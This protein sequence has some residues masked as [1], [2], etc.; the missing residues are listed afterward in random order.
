MRLEDILRDARPPSADA[1]PRKIPWDEPAF[2][3]RMLYEHLSQSHDGASRRPERIDAHVAWLDRAVLRGRASRI[4]DLGCGPGL[5]TRRL[6]VLGHECTGIDF[7]PASVTFARDHAEREHDAA[8]YVLGDV[9]TVDFGGPYDL[10]MMLFGEINAFT[11]DEAVAVLTR[12]RAALAD[13][14]L[15]LLEASRLA[16]LRRDTERP[17]SWRARSSGLFSAQPHLEL[18]EHA[19]H[20]ATR[21]AVTRWYVVDTATAEVARYGEVLQGYDDEGYESLLADAGLSV[22]RRIAGLTGDADTDADFVVLMAR[23]RG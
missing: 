19:W 18:T 15:V 13:G 12:A 8:H 10:V 2:S 3:A 5:Y 6:A 7:S 14:G 9:R 20:D 4:L 17:R 1:G 16:A 22:E 21:Q 11:R 23:S